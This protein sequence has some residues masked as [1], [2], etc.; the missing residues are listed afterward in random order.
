MWTDG[1]Y[2]KPG[3]PG[4]PAYR[5]DSDRCMDSRND[6]DDETHEFE[7][8]I[9]RRGAIIFAIVLLILVI[10]TYLDAAPT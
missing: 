7:P 6:I 9:T 8:L 3:L 4:R 2:Q 10:T 1:Y 5:T